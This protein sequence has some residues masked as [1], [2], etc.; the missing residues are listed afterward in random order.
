MAKKT[1]RSHRKPAA[2][3]RWLVLSAWEPELVELRRLLKMEAQ[4]PTIIAA[5]VGVGLVEAALGATLA[6]AR[7]QPDAV[8][9][10]GTAGQYQGR[11][12]GL[13]LGDVVAASRLRLWSAEVAAGHAYFP[14]PLPAMLKTP[15]A[16]CR[17]AVAQGLAL[18]D[19]ACPVAI[20]TRART[21]RA[22]EDFPDAEN[23]EAFA[24]ARAVAIQDLPFIAILG[25][26]NLVGPAA[27][28]QWKQHART[29]AAAACR[30]AYA[31]ITASG[32]PF[33]RAT[34]RQ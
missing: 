21:A 31:L 30:A 8:L 7:E 16:L 34:R 13:D 2:P 17:L 11:L 33:H 26:S 19:V 32:R 29:A 3:R 5:P 4:G 15:P 22:Q 9:F 28:A 1:T 10:V 6:I 18:A 14:A 27:H 12:R 23:L 25:L 20:S 24:V